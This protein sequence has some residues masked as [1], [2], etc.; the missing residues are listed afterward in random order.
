M[1]AVSVNLLPR[2]QRWYIRRQRLA[3]WIQM[4]SMGLAGVYAV[5]L[6]VLFSWRLIMSGQLK[7]VEGR[8]DQAKGEI[9]ALAQVE[10]QQVLVKSKAAR[11]VQLKQGQANLASF[12]GQ[13][14]DLF[15]A[16][17]ELTDVTIKSA[18]EVELTGKT[19][20]PI[21]LSEVLDKLQDA[22]S[23]SGFL[24]QVSLNSVTKS[25]VGEYSFTVA[26]VPK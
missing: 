12:L 20:N 16:E 4:A 8:I 11:L 9:E 17:V 14:L 22:E 5:L 7:T 19:F 3:R 10:S 26:V 18:K 6:L 2:K 25:S 13:L 24:S 21:V 1:K 15:P 23:L